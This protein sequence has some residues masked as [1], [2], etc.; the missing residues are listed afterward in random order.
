[1][2][3]SFF[4]RYPAI[5]ALKDRKSDMHHEA[6]KT[7]KCATCLQ[8]SMLSIP[9]PSPPVYSGNNMISHWHPV[10]EHPFS[11]PRLL[12]QLVK[13]HHHGWGLSAAHCSDGPG[14]SPEHH[15]GNP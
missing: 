8:R 5:C 9:D 6:L 10:R 1:M 15:P 13:P 3:L 2:D 12:E 14:F 7:D 4:L 11:Q